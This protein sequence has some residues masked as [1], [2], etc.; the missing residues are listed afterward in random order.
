MSL[1]VSN[2]MIFF[3]IKEQMSSNLNVTKVIERYVKGN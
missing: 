1:N 2:L 3:E